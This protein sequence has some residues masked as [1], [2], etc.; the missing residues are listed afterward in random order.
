MGDKNSVAQTEDSLDLTVKVGHGIL[1]A[2]YTSETGD[3]SWIIRDGIT[4]CPAFGTVTLCNPVCNTFSCAAVTVADVLEERTASGTITSAT[5]LEQVA[6]CGTITVSCCACMLVGEVHALGAITMAC[7]TV[8]STSCGTITLVAVAV[9]TTVCVNGRE[10]T[11]VCGT[12]ADHTEFNIAGTDCVDATDL[13]DSLNNDTRCPTC[14]CGT[15]NTIACNVITVTSV[16]T[17]LDSNC[18]VLT[19][20]CNCDIAISACGFTCGKDTDTVTVN[21]L[22]YTART[23]VKSCD[24]EF[25][26][27]SGN[28][29]TIATDLAD[30]I[31][32]DVRA[33]GIDDLTATGCA[34]IVTAVSTVAGTGGNAITISDTAGA[35]ITSA[36]TFSGGINGDF[37]TINGLVYTATVGAKADDTEFSIDTSIC[38]AATDL[39][40]SIDD[41]VRVGTIFNLTSTAAGA[42]VTS[43]VACV[44]AGTCGNNIEQLTSDSCSL[45]LSCMNFENGNTADT[46]TVNGLTYTAVE[47]AG[48]TACMIFSTDTSDNATAT[49][50][51][52]RINCDAT[53]GTL[54]CLDVTAAAC[55]AVVTV[56]A[57]CSGASS[58]AIT[59]TSTDAGTLAVSGCGTLAGGND[60]CTLTV[61]GLTYT[62]VCG[63]GSTACMQ[64]S[65]DVSNNNTATDLALRIND[66]TVCGTTGD[67]TATACAA[68]VTIVTD[69]CGVAGDA[70]TI[71]SSC[72][73]TLG[74]GCGFEGGVD[75]DTV[76]INGL[77]YTAT[78]AN[79]ACAG[80]WDN[81]CMSSTN[82]ATVVMCDGR[83][84]V[85]VPTHDVSGVAV[86]CVVTITADA[87]EVGS[88][89]DLASSSATRLLTSGAFLSGGVGREVIEIDLVGATSGEISIP[90]P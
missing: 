21:C 27:S 80:E 23:G 2:I 44:C 70:I 16:D 30:S 51:A 25:D 20:S 63:A 73:T 26:V 4:V 42:V 72:G 87:G 6:A 57:A 34:A 12:K 19:S 66:D 9:A 52:T 3:R 54:P 61:N 69:V 89:I 28:N 84:P 68:I 78:C 55:A 62:A 41:D 15:T 50:L 14:T 83:T 43:V 79:C 60:A 13:L 1:K 10:Y 29:T 24:T 36:A 22:V 48:C 75:A 46:V 49:D 86:A 45:T 81:S 82:F 33:G 90:H 18:I 8:D 31:D 38:A 35:R 39:A 7:P 37:V 74:V 71:S 40:D 59:L 11:A 77:T 32:D 64:F 67:Q 58:N 65:T 88:C 47:G 53:A 5:T 17:G 76:T 85:T 56:T